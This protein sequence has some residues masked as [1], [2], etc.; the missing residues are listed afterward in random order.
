MTAVPHSLPR[1]DACWPGLAVAGAV[2]GL[3]LLVARSAAAS[4][5]VVSPMLVALLLGLGLAQLRPLPACLLPGLSFAGRT[6]LR[7]AIVL[8]GLRI[9]LAEIV[10]VGG[11]GLVGIGL[12]V[13][14]TVAFGGWVGRRL[15]LSDDLA[16]LLAVGHAIC[17]AAAI[18]AAD[19][20]LRCQPREVAR[21]LT[22][23]T[24]FGTLAMLLAPLAGA[25][26]ALEAGPYGFWVGGSV[27]EVAQAVAAGY[28][29]G[30]AHGD[31]A[32]LVKMVRV[33]FLLP[34]GL[35]LGRVAARRAGATG[36][37]L[38]VP[39]FVVGFVALAVLDGAGAIPAEVET[40]LVA[41][42]P[43]VMTVA[44]AAIGLQGSLRELAATGWRPVLA[45]AATTVFVSAAAGVVASCCG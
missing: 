11:R 5:F 7:A 41:A 12:V 29:R 45:A 10:G 40:P 1:R 16:R 34:V 36:R 20:L 9:G 42:G 3:A 31:H 44:M 19:S 28:A 33:A 23:V 32:S 26:F 39:W 6:L 8:L 17:G 24:L 30:E 35:W 14:S 37:R 22:L 27:H 43:V 4:G 21:A 38:V 18:A 15:G 25:A 13:V 2:A